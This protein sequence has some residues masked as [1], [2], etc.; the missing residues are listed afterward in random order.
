MVI[1]GPGAWVSKVSFS[2][3]GN[4]I[5]IASQS[6]AIPFWITHPRARLAQIEPS[7]LE[8]SF[9]PIHTPRRASPALI[10]AIDIKRKMFF[11]LD[12]TPFQI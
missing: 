10:D 11:E 7:E 9:I 2:P 8:G 1:D 6:G 4:E 3:N 5:A 12:G